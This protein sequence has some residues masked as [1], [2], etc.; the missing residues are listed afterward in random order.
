[1]NPRL[2][3]FFIIACI[4]LLAPVAAIATEKNP[5]DEGP[6]QPAQETQGDSLSMY[7]DDNKVTDPIMLNGQRLSSQE[8]FA[9]EV[10]VNYSQTSERKTVEEQQ[11]EDSN[12]AMSFN[13]IYYIIDKFK[14]AD[15]LD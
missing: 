14:L 3:N 4:F 10:S 8:E 12:S 11:Q 2:K 1:M 6:P 5:K 9:E 15:P 13:F 7:A